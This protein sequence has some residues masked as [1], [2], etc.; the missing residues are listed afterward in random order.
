M[1]VN[2]RVRLPHL[3]VNRPQLR[4]QRLGTIR[5]PRLHQR[6]VLV[7][8][9]GNHRHRLAGRWLFVPLK[10]SGLHYRPPKVINTINTDQQVFQH[11]L[12]A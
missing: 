12:P 4:S 11:R 3:L 9:D 6:E 1:F 7:E 8:V 10:E 2:V 5:E